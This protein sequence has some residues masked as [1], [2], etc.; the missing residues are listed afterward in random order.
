MS[1]AHAL[2]L[3]QKGEV[4][5]C[6]A[7]ANFDTGEQNGKLVVSPIKVVFPGETLPI[8]D[9]AA[10][11]HHSVFITTKTVYV[12]GINNNFCLGL[13][14]DKGQYSMKSVKLPMPEGVKK[15]QLEKVTSVL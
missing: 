2:F 3:T 14:R 11:P 12:C 10:G 8:V 13:K 4:Y 6:G 1:G 5:A 7:A 9:I 15:L